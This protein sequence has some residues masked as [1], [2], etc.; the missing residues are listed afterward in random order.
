MPNMPS[1]LDFSVL[2]PASAV[3]TLRPDLRFTPA[4]F[5]GEA[6][7]MIE[8]PVRGKFFRIGGD[9]FSLISLLD[10]KNTIAQAIGL[11]AATL[12]ERAFMENEAMSVCHWLLES[13]LAA[14]GG[15]GQ[16]ERL[17]DSARKQAQ[18]KLAASI[19]PLAMRLPLFNPSRVL[20]HIVPCLHWIVGPPAVVAWC[21]VCLIGLVVAAGHRGELVESSSVLLDRDNWLR[22]AV[23]WLILKVLHETA[24]AVTCVHFG[25]TVPSAGVLLVV[26]TPLPFV[27]RD[28]LLAFSLEMAADRHRR[29][30]RLS[31]IVRGRRGN[32][33]LEL[34]GRFGRAARRPER[35]RHR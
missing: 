15:A 25:G 32:Y 10:G 35:G 21:V 29:R 7:Y 27:E 8:D 31:R 34:L 33:P 12:H 16:A 22:L 11:S 14:C 24:H 19:N 1:D 6:C 9:E 30:R 13:Q 28:R 17:A 23:V 18:N 26:F 5:D 2:D 3:L 4:E 20:N